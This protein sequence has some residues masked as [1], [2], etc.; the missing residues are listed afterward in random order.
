MSPRVTIKSIAKDLGISHMTVSRALSNHPNVLK[1]TREAIQE[2]ARKV[3]YVKS[4]A[5]KAMRG[6]ETRIVGL[7]LPNIV[8]EFYARFANTMA[9]ACEEQSLQLIIHLTGDDIAAEEKALQRL[10]EIQAQGVV[11]VPAPGHSETELTHLRAMSV[12]QL[13]RQSD[14]GEAT[15]SILV[16]DRTALKNAVAHLA[17]EGHKNI[18]FIGAD[19]RLSSGRSRL[20]AFRAG[21]ASAGIQEEPMLVCTGPPS[22]EMGLKQAK[23]LIEQKKATALICGGFEISNGALNALMDAGLSPSGPMAFVGYGDPSFY[24]WIGGGVSTISVPVESLAYK[25]VELLGQAAF[26]IQEHRFDAVLLVRS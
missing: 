11:M 1:E 2:H 22:A 7:L 4:A 5:A 23:R 15:P 6:D 24:S 21:L 12:I 16:N 25:A 10:H 20:A 9:L 14:T 19:S 3:G 8:N 18:A 13:I 17:A 26:E